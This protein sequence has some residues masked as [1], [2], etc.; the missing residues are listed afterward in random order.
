MLKDLLDRN[1]ISQ[2]SYNSAS[3]IL[4]TRDTRS[5]LSCTLTDCSVVTD[6]DLT[7]SGKTYFSMD[8]I[9]RRMEEDRERVCHFTFHYL[10]LSISFYVRVYG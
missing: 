4:A 7:Q 6:V 5:C 9:K 3:S 1:L 8:E 2:T 10:T